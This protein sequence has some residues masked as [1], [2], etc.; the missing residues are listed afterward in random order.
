MAFLAELMDTQTKR[1]PISTLDD[2]VMWLAEVDSSFEFFPIPDEGRTLA[3]V[4]VVTVEGEVIQHRRY[5]GDGGFDA[6]GTLMMACRDL[7][8]KVNA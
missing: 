8:Q 4:I 6:R 3:I 2:A 5:V 7:W 1:N